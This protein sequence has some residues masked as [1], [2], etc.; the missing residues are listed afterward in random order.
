MSNY[1]LTKQL[2]HGDIEKTAY[3]LWEQAG[4]PAGRDH[5]FW[6]LA[7]QQ[8]ILAQKEAAITSVEITPLPP[9]AKSVPIEPKAKV[10][11]SH[12]SAKPAVKPVE[13]AEIKP[14]VK[15]EVKATVKE[16]EK[17]AVIKPA[18]PVVEPVKKPV[19]PI[20][21]GRKSRNR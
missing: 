5:E 12:P 13:T 3:Y 4:R 17:P 15:K 11:T 7:E 8:L 18:A 19:T 20:A 9:V 1:N 10:E 21:K 14:S 16:I 2:N 6:T